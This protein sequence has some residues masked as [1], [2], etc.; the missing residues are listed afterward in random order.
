MVFEA[1]DAAIESTIT[2]VFKQ[3]YQLVNWL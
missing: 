1:L 3:S 2:S